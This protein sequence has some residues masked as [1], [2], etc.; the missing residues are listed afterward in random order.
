MD[1]RKPIII[2]SGIAIVAF[3]YFS[4][5]LLGG[6]KQT[7]PRKPAEVV[8]RY[9]KAET[10]KYSNVV[11]SI[12]AM[13]R[14]SS[15]TE[16][17]LIAEVRGKLIHGDISFKVGESFKKGD[18]IVKIDDSIEL[19]NMKSR[20]SSFLNNVASVLPDLKASL[21]ESYNKWSS[22]LY[23]IDIDKNLPELPEINSP[24]E[25]IFMASR[26]ILTNYY[27]IKSAEANFESYR[28][29]APFNGTITEVNFEEGAV[30]NSGTKLGK[31]I[32]TVNLELEVP[33]DL[34]DS[35][36]LSTGQKVEVFNSDKTSK[37]VGEIVRKANDINP[38][39]QSINVYVSLN[40]NKNNPIYKGEYFT[41]V[42]AGIKL[43]KVMEIPRNA[44]FNQNVVFVV[45]N[46]LLLQRTI[47]VK[48]INKDKLFFVGLAEGTEVVSEP[49]INASENSSVK[50][51]GKK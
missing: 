48:K 7:P 25:R 51:L 29:Y 15:Q 4:M 19:Y 17:S 9:V 50:I 8:D 5:Q 30:A 32:N 18:L 3:A 49:L 46:G 42:F 37:W 41:A 44:V 24:Q 28:I 35:K 12:E 16:V 36:W 21:P 33:V 40:S 38:N 1:K 22:Y 34:D 20:K 13:G 39:T 31:I 43:A 27:T 11:T 2:I 14:V 45:E 6:M 47:N 23:S 26:N 10:V